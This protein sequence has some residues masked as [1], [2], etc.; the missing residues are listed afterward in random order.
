[1][2]EQLAQGTSLV[3]VVPNVAI[4]LWSYARRSRL[5]KRIA[6]AL[7]GAAFPFTIVAAHVATHLPS[8]HLRVAFACFTLTIAGYTAFRALVPSR[9]TGSPGGRPWPI[10]LAVGAGGGLL[11]G[12]FGV[13]GAIFSVPIVAWLYGLTQAAAQG[14]GLALVA[15]GT[16]AGIATYGFAGDVDWVRGGA[17]ALGGFLAVPSGVRMAH[18]I[19][20]RT[21]RIAFALLMS[22]G[23][24]GLLVRPG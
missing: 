19:P 13:G 16:L 9:A 11:S 10:A 2:N 24:I 15:P 18:A 17:L 14:Y 3:M 1:M 4:G 6:L 12:L 5:D 20:E 23:A 7:A 21:L 8:A 22:A